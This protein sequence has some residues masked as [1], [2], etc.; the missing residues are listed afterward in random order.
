MILVPSSSTRAVDQEAGLLGR[1]L[2]E[3]AARLAEVERV[4]V[5]AV[6]EPA[7]GCRPR[8]MRSIQA[9][10]LGVVGAPGDVVD[11]ARALA[12]ALGG[13]G[14]EA[15]SSRRAC[16]PRSSKRSLVTV[17][18]RPSCRSSSARSRSGAARRRARPRSR[19]ARARRGSPGA[20]RPAARR[21]SVDDEL[22]VE[23]L[24]VGEAQ[25][26]VVALDRDALGAEPLGPE[27]ERLGEPTRQTIR[28][29]M[30][31]PGRPG[32]APGYSKNVRSAPG[33]AS[34]SP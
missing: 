13:R 10:Q 20:R 9:R 26:A 1:Q 25:R 4:E 18:R 14:I 30:P 32:I 3:D 28:W 19:G 16:S 17:A 27:V 24:G 11:G 33:C 21:R 2:V 7:L 23:P 34:S 8:S 15:R 31:A 12:A 6:D 29:T 5:V 22:V